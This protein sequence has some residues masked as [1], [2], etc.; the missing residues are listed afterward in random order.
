MP[1]LRL[2]LCL[3]ALTALV[4]LVGVASAGPASWRTG[5]PACQVLPA[6][7]PWNTD[8]SKYP[9]HP[10]SNAYIDAIGRTEHLHPDVG[11]AGT[12]KRGP[13]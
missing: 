8:V 4:A 1:K 13:S 12:A 3:I 2:P 5:E 9:L 7:N 6:N 10:R 11:T